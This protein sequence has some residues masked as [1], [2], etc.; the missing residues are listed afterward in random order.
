MGR[1]DVAIAWS[2]ERLSRSLPELFGTLSSLEDAGVD[3]YFC[4]QAIDTA[5][6]AGR[7]FLRILKAFSEL[8]KT[9]IGSRVTAGISRARARGV[10]LGRPRMAEDVESAIKQQ[11]DVGV[12]PSKV[13]EG[14]GVSVSTV[15]R[16]KA[17]I[18]A[19]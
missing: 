15:R 9:M 16:I 14:M 6:P 7:M 19:R 5:E 4:H 12:A 1:F 10:R 13:A 18:M 3:L 2:V 11:L 17:Q 8:E